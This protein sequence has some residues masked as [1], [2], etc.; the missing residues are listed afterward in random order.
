MTKLLTTPTEHVAL[1]ISDV[2]LIGH[3]V[4]VLREAGY[5]AELAGNRITVDEQMVACYVSANGRFWWNVY[6]I[7][8]QA[9]T[10]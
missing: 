1:L 5:R 6:P 9:T 4:N 8:A 10:R 2:A 7:D 3:A